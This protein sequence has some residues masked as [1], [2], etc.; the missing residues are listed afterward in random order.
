MLQLQQ[1]TE[2]SDKHAEAHA[3]KPALSLLP[4]AAPTRLFAAAVFKFE[5][6][7]QQ[8][9]FLLFKFPL[10]FGFCLYTFVFA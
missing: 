2:V 8:N 9:L 10:T 5:K 4:K 7:P 3:P 6:K 1:N